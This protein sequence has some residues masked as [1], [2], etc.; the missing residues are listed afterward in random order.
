MKS[1]KIAAFAA[2]T[3]LVFAVPAQSARR[4]GLN[5][6]ILVEDHDDVFIFPQKAH[7]DHNANRVRMDHS[8]NGTA[9]TIFSKSGKGAW[10]LGIAQG[11]AEH[12]VIDAFYSMGDLGFRL[13]LASD[14]QKTDGEGAS[15]MGLGIA[16]GYAIK[17]VG[18]AAL[19]FRMN[20]TDDGAD[21]TTSGMVVAVAFRGY[22]A[23]GAGDAD[24]GYTFTGGF[25][26]NSN[27]PAMGDSQDSSSI[28]VEAGVGP[29]WR[30]G[31]STVAVHATVGFNQ[32]TDAAENS[33]STIT[34]PG[35]NVAFET[36]LNDW[37]DFR[38]G[39][40][41][42]FALESTTPKEGDPTSAQSGSTTAAMGLSA[43][44][45]KLNFDVALNRDFLLNGPYM[46][47]G[48]AT[49]GWASNVAATY[50]W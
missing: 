14:A 18:D 10:G 37:V 41:Y 38:G 49:A 27:T 32:N 8:A 46:L 47:T 3:V 24:L 20:N 5:N 19:H 16:A 35:V 21:N 43:H 30:L 4:D 28:N 34:V 26:S 29:V 15:S 48:N 33:D 36:P 12:A 2:L 25:S 17:G 9:A 6:N 45:G 50:K 31:K 13:E 40:G 11:D 42:G 1:L 44:W 22:K 23:K 39:A 7:S